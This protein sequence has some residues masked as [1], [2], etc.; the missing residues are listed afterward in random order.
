MAPLRRGRG[1]QPTFQEIKVQPSACAPAG[2]SGQVVDTNA[3]QIA[4]LRQWLGANQCWVAG[5][6]PER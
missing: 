3:K 4:H 2:A 6:A 5:P 1:R